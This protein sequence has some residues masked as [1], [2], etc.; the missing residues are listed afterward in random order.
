MVAPPALVQVP[1]HWQLAQSVC[2]D[3]VTQEIL[4][5]GQK[6]SVAVPPAP[7]YVPSDYLPQVLPLL[8]NAKGDNE[9][10][11]GAVHISPGIYLTPEDN[12]WE[13]YATNHCLK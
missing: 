8:A 1:S 3:S 13:G 2:I 9:V 10:K 4:G 5:C 12:L 6:S 11:P 7:V